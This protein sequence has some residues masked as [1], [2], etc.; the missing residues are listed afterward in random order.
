MAMISSPAGPVQGFHLV[1]GIETGNSL[2]FGQWA[3][4][5]ERTLSIGGASLSLSLSPETT[6]ADGRGLAAGMMENPSWAAFLW[7]NDICC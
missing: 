3:Y 5:A 7:S 4:Q 2:A 6:H 1:V